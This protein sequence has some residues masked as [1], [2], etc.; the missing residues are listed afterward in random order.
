MLDRSDRCTPINREVLL[1]HGGEVQLRGDF[2]ASRRQHDRRE[3]RIVTL[4]VL[5][6]D[7]REESTAAREFVLH[8]RGRDFPRLNAGVDSEG[9][10]M[11]KRKL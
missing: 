11:R 2:H 9:T 1:P 3:L 6:A 8:G 7:G 5:H 4:D 10:G